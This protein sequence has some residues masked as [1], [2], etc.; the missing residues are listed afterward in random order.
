MVETVREQQWLTKHYLH[1]RLIVQSNDI[2]EIT[3][4][5]LICPKGTENIICTVLK[6]VET[7]YG[8]HT[9]HN[10]ICIKDKSTSCATQKLLKYATLVNGN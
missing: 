5:G 10:R 6:Y 9:E 4:N 3:A 7:F 1:A 8:D 2:F